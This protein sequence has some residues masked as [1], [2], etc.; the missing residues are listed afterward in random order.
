MCGKEIDP[1][2][3]GHNGIT[4]NTIVSVKILFNTLK[5]TKLCNGKTAEPGHKSSKFRI[6]QEWS[7]C[8][9]EYSVEY[10]LEIVSV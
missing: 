3:I 8:G 7:I 9:N 1:S 2:I 4:C 6:L 10:H 5:Q